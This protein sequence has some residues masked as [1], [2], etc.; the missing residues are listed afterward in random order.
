MELGQLRHAAGNLIRVGPD[1]FGH[2]RGHQ[3]HGVGEGHNGGSEAHEEA[4]V[5]REDRVVVG[6]LVGVGRGKEAGVDA[7]SGGAEEA[8][9]R[10]G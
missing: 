7:G 10:E 6:T 4:A 9:R 5:L 3:G 1:E 8:R 2:I